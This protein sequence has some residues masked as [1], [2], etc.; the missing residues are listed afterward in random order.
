MPRDISREFCANR[1]TAYQTIRRVDGSRFHQANRSGNKMRKGKLRIALILITSVRVKRLVSLSSTRPTFPFLR[2]LFSFFFRLFRRFSA[3]SPL[4]LSE[5]TKY[6]A[7]DL[8]PD[9]KAGLRGASAAPS[10]NVKRS[11]LDT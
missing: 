4:D 5:L 9:R 2:K 10:P 8:D 11:G 6:L 7:R 1:S 3:A